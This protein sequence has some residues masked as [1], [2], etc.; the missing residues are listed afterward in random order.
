M[1]RKYPVSAYLNIRLKPP[2]A[3]V[4][5]PRDLICIRVCHVVFTSITTRWEEPNFFEYFGW[6]L[7]YRP[8]KVA[9][10]SRS[11]RSLVDFTA[12]VYCDLTTCI[13][14]G[15]YRNCKWNLRITLII[16]AIGAYETSVRV[17]CIRIHPV[18][19]KKIRLQKNSPFPLKNYYPHD[20]GI[21]CSM[22]NLRITLVI[23]PVGE[24]ET[25]ALVYRNTARHI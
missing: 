13:L 24:Y 4:N 5:Q 20:D 9:T 3:Y 14:V 8:K 18:A 11:S 19:N 6:A 17:N 7:F 10:N 12:F 15:T 21:L 2:T 1:T 16:E 23:E 25:S 22:W